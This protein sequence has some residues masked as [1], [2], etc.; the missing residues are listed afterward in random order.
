MKLPANYLEVV[1]LGAATLGSLGTRLRK[2]AAKKP[3]MPELWLS[4]RTFEGLGGRLAESD[5]FEWRHGF[6][7]LSPLDFGVL[8][9][10]LARGGAESVPLS[11]EEAAALTE[12]RAF[13]NRYGRRE[14]ELDEP[15]A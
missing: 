2:I 6:V 10:L 1:H 5:D 7:M 15:A 14:Y 4:V 12:L 9:E 3:E 8:D 13:L 11:A